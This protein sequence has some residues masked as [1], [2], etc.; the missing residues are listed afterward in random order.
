MALMPF[1]GIPGFWK[2]VFFFFGGLVISGLA[3]LL[4]GSD[5]F[6]KEVKAK[7]ISYSE[8]EPEADVEGDRDNDELRNTN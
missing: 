4:N 6:V 5:T 1:S 7:N 3:F 8:R 2:N